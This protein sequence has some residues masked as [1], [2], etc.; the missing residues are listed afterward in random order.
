[1]DPPTPAV[2][3]RERKFEEILPIREY[4]RFASDVKR[5]WKSEEE[6]QPTI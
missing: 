1:V 4:E 3:A 6:L 5:R 2:Q